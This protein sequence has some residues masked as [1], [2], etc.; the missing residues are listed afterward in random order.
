MSNKNTYLVTLK[1]SEYY[2]YKGRWYARD[3]E[4]EVPYDVYLY[5]SRNRYFVT[6]VIPEVEPPKKVDD[7][8]KGPEKPEDKKEAGE[9]K[10][11]EVEEIIPIGEEPT[12]AESPK[13]TRR[14]PFP[15]Q[16]KETEG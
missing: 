16:N 2:N 11:P 15:K 4:T 12:K 7:I 9:E 8:V 6:R 1:G 10:A 14:G 13:T 3:I 5:L